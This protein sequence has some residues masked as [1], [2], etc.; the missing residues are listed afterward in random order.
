MIDESALKDTLLSMATDNR[1]AYVMMSSL[2]NEVA[3]LRETVR[4][5]DPTFAMY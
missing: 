1:M 2:L 5:L 3:S 4:G